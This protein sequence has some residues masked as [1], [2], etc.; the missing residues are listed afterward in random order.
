MV[1]YLCGLGIWEESTPPIVQN[2]NPAPSSTGNR[3]D[4]AVYLE[5]YDDDGNLDAS[6][7]KIWVE[8]S[9]AWSSAS[10]G[11]GW[12]GS[13]GT[14]TKGHSYTFTPDTPLPAGSTITVRVYAEDDDGN[15]LDETYTF[16]TGIFLDSIE[17]DPI[18]ERGG[19]LVTMTGLFVVAE[20]L[21]VRIAG[22]PCYG[23]QNKGYSPSSDDGLIVEIASPPLTVGGIQLVTVEGSSGELSGLIG[24][25]E[26]SWPKAE[27]EARRNHPP[28]SALGARRL[29]MESLIEFPEEEK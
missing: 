15:V 10:A 13:R 12:T 17:P 21:D 18:S 7:V 14:I 20:P 26:R 27:F 28:W 2:Q 11:S 24:V 22:E 4:G 8:G 16:D 23:G 1:G 3:G 29:E 19:Q 9:L 25:V 5:V 6:T